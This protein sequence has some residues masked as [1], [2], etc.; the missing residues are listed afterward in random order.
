MKRITEVPVFSLSS[1]CSLWLK[2]SA[3]SPSILPAPLFIQRYMYSRLRWNAFSPTSVILPWL[4]PAPSLKKEKSKE[5][6]QNE[7][8]EHGKLDNQRM[9]LRCLLFTADQRTADP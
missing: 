8:P 1:L 3:P 2:F 5:G 9:S 4:P 7:K 6:I